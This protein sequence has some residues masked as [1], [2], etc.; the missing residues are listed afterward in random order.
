MI[1]INIVNENKH[2]KKICIRGHAGYDVSGKDIVC[3]AVSATVLTTINIIDCLKNNYINCIEEKDKLTI[4]VNDKD[5][6]INKILSKMILLIKEI[7]ENY[8]SYIEINEE[9]S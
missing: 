2:I 3:A 4:V 7:K 1:K 9:V 5:N 6:T 8:P